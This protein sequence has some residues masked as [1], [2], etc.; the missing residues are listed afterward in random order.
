MKDLLEKLLEEVPKYMG[1]FVQCI[2]NPKEFFQEQLITGNNREIV[3]KS[4]SFV[5]LSLLIAFVLS[6]LFPATL[7]INDSLGA[8]D[9]AKLLGD[10]NQFI[11]FVVDILSSAF[12]LLALTTVIYF[13]WRIVGTPSN[14][15]Q[16]FGFISFSLSIF[17]VLS[18]FIEAIPN[19]AQIDPAVGRG[20][21]KL[22]KE[23]KQLQPL[24]EY[25]LCNADPNTGRFSNSTNQSKISDSARIAAKKLQENFSIISERPLYKIAHR[26]RNLFGIALTIWFARSWFA[27][28]KVQGA[29]CFKIIVSFIIAIIGFLF[30]AFIDTVVKMSA[31][32]M[33]VYRKC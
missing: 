32:M 28:G 31:L 30:L 2:V 24:L 21:I 13:A 11:K 26:L 5:I 22:E 19:I 14:F 3:E 29:S 18:V 15:Q 7:V 25:T 20:L 17:I 4:L 33:Q 9:L 12:Y 23:V 10:D 1:H 8:G 6:K 16:C 27:F